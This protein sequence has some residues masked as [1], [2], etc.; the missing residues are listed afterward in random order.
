MVEVKMKNLE[1]IAI[2][3]TIGFLVASEDACELSESIVEKYN[4]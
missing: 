1:V 4:K 2:Q 3:A